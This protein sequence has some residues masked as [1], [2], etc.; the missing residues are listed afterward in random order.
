MLGTFGYFEGLGLVGHDHEAG[1][2]DDDV[3]ESFRFLLF[4]VVEVHVF[5]VYVLILFE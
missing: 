4:N 5:D 3:K 1:A 2:K